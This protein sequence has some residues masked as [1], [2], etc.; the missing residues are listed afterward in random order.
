MDFWAKLT[1]SATKRH[2]LL[3]VG[4]D[5]Y[6]ERM[7]ARF[8]S[9]AAFLKHIIEVTAD[10]A[11]IYKPNI[12]FFEAL[13][14]EG[15]RALRQVIEHVPE[16]RPVLLDA[17]RNDISSTAS[18][19]ARAVFDV[20]GVD[21]LTVNPYLGYDGIAP[22]LAYEDRGVF[23]LCKTSNPSAGQVQDWSQGG[24]P[25]YRHIAELAG[26]W[27]GGREIGLVVGATYPEAI[28]DI[29]ARHER[30]WF[31]VPGV[32]AQGG[33]LQAALQAGLR[34]DGLGMLINAS[35]GI[36]YA[37]DP[38]EAA[39][40]LCEQING[41]R[42]QTRA[43]K[44]ADERRLPRVLALARA[45]HDAGCVQFGDFVLHSGAHS[46][47]YVDLRRLVTYPE[48]LARVAEAY[49]ELLRQLT[50]D[51]IAAIPYAA[52]PIGSAV[53]L[54]TG[55]P[56]IYPR[57]EAKAYGTRRQIEGVYA[58]G[59]T[60]VVLDDL[61]S[62]G[63]SKLEAIDVLEEAGLHVSDVVVLI[64]REQGGRRDLAARGYALHAVLTLREMVT[65]LVNDGRLS[66]EEG[67]RVHRYLDGDA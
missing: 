15:M 40:A 54:R 48:A 38:R 29:R 37:E 8:G 28:A 44:G 31:L 63:G 46:P 50:F 27:S 51:R 55:Q 9:V 67:I 3:C 53:I 56:M 13:G 7:P 36:L 25:L 61:I 32:G 42:S 21:A 11:C 47:V 58:P 64:D 16:D 65:A 22:F 62:S 14:E 18:A 45:L 59:E 20:L 41:V 39:E 6:P 30:C 1:E 34:A 17:K 66:A 12:A 23:V 19:Y 57:R 2:S 49:G 60:A 26:E 43:H 35:R 10:Q 33:D 52:L 24:A 4:L 5:P